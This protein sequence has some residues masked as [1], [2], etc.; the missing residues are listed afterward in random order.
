MTFPCLVPPR[1]RIEE[2]AL[3][4]TRGKPC[5]HDPQE[6]RGY[7]VFSKACFTGYIVAAYIPAGG[8]TRDEC[9]QKE[10]KRHSLRDAENR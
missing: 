10:Q 1:Y 6:L 4:S 9:R 3:T 2:C 7:F 5:R 8:S